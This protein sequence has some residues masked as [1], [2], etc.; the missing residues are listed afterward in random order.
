MGRP[1]KEAPS[2]SPLAPAI[3]RYVR[4]RGADASS[5]IERFDLAAEVEFQESAPVTALALAE[6]LEAAAS[7]LGEPHLALRLPDELSFP[8]Y[9]LAELAARASANLREA[10]GRMSRYATLIHPL[11]EIGFD[12]VGGEARVWNRTRGYPRGTGRHMHEYGLAKALTSSRVASGRPIAASRVWFIHARPPELGALE[13]FF[14]TRQLQFGCA[15][16]GLAIPSELLDL[17]LGGGDPRM[18]ATV[19]PLAEAALAAQPAA[20]DFA[21]RVAERLRALLPGDAR[22]E[23]VA[24]AMH[25][26]ERTLQRRLEQEGTCFTDVL[27]GVRETLARQWVADRAQPLGD[28]AYRL[29]FSDLPT[30]SRAFRRWTGKPPGTWRRFSA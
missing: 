1:L 15:D 19:E 17:P 4:A 25:M 3:V 13:R 12:D 6:L 18:L 14:G 16:N 24:R 2:P 9:G 8:R 21:A 11:L 7:M 5:L 23:A 10:W 28:I 20:D 30:F 29:G 27:D 22:M 26:S